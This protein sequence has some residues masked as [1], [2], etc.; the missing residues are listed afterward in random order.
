MLIPGKLYRPNESLAFRPLLGR[1]DR[2]T[3]ESFEEH[4]VLV[5]L[6][7]ENDATGGYSGDGEHYFFHFLLNEQVIVTW[8][9]IHPLGNFL[10][11]FDP[12]T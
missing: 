12:V 2:N 5:F 4:H 10:L 7:T 8:R 6:K 1:D 11:F 3:T 9:G